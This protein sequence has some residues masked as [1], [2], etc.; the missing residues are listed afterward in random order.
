MQRETTWRWSLAG[1]LLG[2]MLGALVLAATFRVF[3]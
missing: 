1:A 3:P 2:S